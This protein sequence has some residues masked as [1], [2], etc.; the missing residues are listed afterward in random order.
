VNAT[1]TTVRYAGFWRRLF[2]FLLD[3]ML[4]SVL[5]L[6]LLLLIY[7]RDYFTWLAADT[8]MLAS[9]GVLD[10]FLSNVLPFILLVIFWRRWQ[11]TPGKLLLDCRV[12]DAQTLQPLTLKQAII[13]A[14]G[15]IV[16][17]L[18]LYL[19]FVWM[20][21]DKRK[22]GLHDKLAG[23]VVI[24]VADDYSEIT[25]PQWLERFSS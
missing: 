9:Y 10:L 15:Y 25:L 8:D 12:V 17:A 3:S 24:Q 14:L 21:W 11:A 6:P 4:F 23:S 7:G 16:S 5:I 1:A 13:R 2:A 19:G 22:Q 18:P 20:A